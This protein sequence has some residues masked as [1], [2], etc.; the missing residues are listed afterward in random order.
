[1]LDKIFNSFSNPFFRI[2]IPDI[3]LELKEEF[4]EYYYLIYEFP[5]FSIRDFLCYECEK[6]IKKFILLLKLIILN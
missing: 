3:P 5:K 6:I 2:D 1:M 4:Y